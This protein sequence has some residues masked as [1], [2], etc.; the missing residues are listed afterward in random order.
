VRRRPDSSRAPSAD[1]D[2]SGQ[3]RA[4]RLAV[5]RVERT[6]QVLGESLIEA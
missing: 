3:Q 2:D 6:P 1:E 4:V 5:G